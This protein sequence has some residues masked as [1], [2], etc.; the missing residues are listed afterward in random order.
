MGLGFLGAGSGLIGY[1]ITQ[2]LVGFEGWREG[3]GRQ[4][5]HVDKNEVIIEQT[6]RIARKHSASLFL[7]EINVKI[8]RKR[9]CLR[10]ASS[11]SSTTKSLG[12]RGLLP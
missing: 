6:F 4:Q 2:C 5:M 7:T 10:A 1:A 9:Q 12:S 11:T 3:Q 8:E